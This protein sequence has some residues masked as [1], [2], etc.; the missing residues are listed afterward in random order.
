MCGVGRSVAS[1]F[2]V[3]T[4]TLTSMPQVGLE[5]TILRFQ[6]STCKTVVAEPEGSL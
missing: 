2:A 1:P 3:G 4:E 6:R 5:H